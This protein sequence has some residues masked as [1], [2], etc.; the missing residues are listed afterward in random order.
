MKK[1]FSIVLTLVLFVSL[2]GVVQGSEANKNQELTVEKDYMKM[3]SSVIIEGSIDDLKIQ[4]KEQPISVFEG[5]SGIEI[6]SFTDE[7]ESQKELKMVYQE[8]MNNTIS[9]ELSYLSHVNIYGD[10]PAGRGVAGHYFLAWTSTPNGLAMADNRYISLYGAEDFSF[11]QMAGTLSH[12]YGHHFSYFYEFENGLNSIDEAFVDTKY[13]QI[14][15]LEQYSKINNGEWHWAPQEIAAEDYR[16]LLG[17]PLGRKEPH[18][19]YFIEYPPN[20]TG[21]Q[22]YWVDVSG[23]ENEVVNFPTQPKITLSKVKDHF[24]WTFLTF[25]STKSWDDETFDLEY[26]LYW[27]ESGSTVM[28][29]TYETDSNKRRFKVNKINFNTNSKYDFW[30]Y[31]KNE[32]GV[33][34]RSEKLTIDFNELDQYISYLSRYSGRNRIETAISVSQEGWQD[35]SKVAFLANG[36]EFADA[37]SGTTLAH[38]YDAPILLTHKNHLSRFVGDE[39]KR[40]GVDTVY[41]LGGVNAVGKEV[42]TELE[43]LGFNI[44]RIAGVDRYHTAAKIGENLGG[45]KD[46][47]VLATGL[48]F[49]DALAVAPF[50]AQL[51]YPVLFSRNSGSLPDFT[52]EAIEDW[53]VENV[54][55]VG[56]ESV[57][58]K[59][60][61]AELEGMGINVSRLAGNNRYQTSIEIVD[62]FTDGDFTDAYVATGENFAD[63]LTGAGLA[64]KR[65]AP[66]LM[67][68]DSI[69]PAYV[70]QYI[71]EVSGG[72]GYILGGEAVIDKEA[73]LRL[74]KLLK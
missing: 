59:E 12:E 4:T 70:E 24:N 38:S 2:S 16:V 19:N 15:N 29:R 23:Y 36:S 26:S 28:S 25:D 32:E 39:L 47:V 22:E 6:R 21:L 54:I 9:K 33:K 51:S 50:A 55:I 34:N 40:L 31:S 41:I 1:L 58:P 48:D 65:E 42:E 74:Q 73:K 66:V 37:L 10:F 17:S 67:I 18:R 49:P 5:P 72:R 71:Q 44:E 13:G 64:A 8:L 69:I 61:E 53:R 14:R 68:N 7:Y 35:G 45:Q 20:V 63:A 30:V 60:V 11:E 43:K 62:Y 52:R 3:E 27:A 57:V 46:T 56:G